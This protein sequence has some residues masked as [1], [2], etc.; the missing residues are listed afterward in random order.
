MQDFDPRSGSAIERALFNHRWLVMALC[1]LVTLVLGWQA[2][3][4]QLNA[5]FEK[6]IPTHHP[7]IAN[8]LKYQSDLTGLGNAVRIAVAPRQGSIYQAAYL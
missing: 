6:T 3:R 2:T 5:S 1:A 4:L 7:Y 8:Y